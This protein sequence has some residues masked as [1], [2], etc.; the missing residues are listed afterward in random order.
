MRNTTIHG[1][2]AIRRNN[3]TGDILRRPPSWTQCALQIPP[4]TP[5]TRKLLIALGLGLCTI[6]ASNRCAACRLGN[7]AINGRNG[8]LILI[9]SVDG[10]MSLQKIP[11]EG[12]KSVKL[13]KVG[14]R[15][16]E[17]STNRRAKDIWHV[18]HL[19][20]LTLVS[21]LE[22]VSKRSEQTTRTT[23]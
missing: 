12:K 15:R 8:F 5:R 6:A 7:H 18:K 16:F 3:N 9:A 17:A 20:G 19:K 13:G 22:I 4:R 2:C 23:Q 1:R 10:V 11:G 21:G 14:G